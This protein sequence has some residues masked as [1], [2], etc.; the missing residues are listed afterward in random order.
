MFIE[1]MFG[2]VCL[3]LAVLHILFLQ[4]ENVKVYFVT[5]D[6]TII[7]NVYFGL[8]RLAWEPPDGGSVE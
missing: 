5:F 7:Y 4:F 2:M 6:V 1:I 8:H 3:L